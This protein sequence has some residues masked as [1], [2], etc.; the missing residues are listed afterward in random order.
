MKSVVKYAFAG[1]TFL[2]VLPVT[3]APLPKQN[4]TLAA[5]YMLGNTTETILPRMETSGAPFVKRNEISA[6]LFVK[7]NETA[8]ILPHAAI[9]AAPLVKRN[10]TVTILPHPAT[11][12]PLARRNEILSVVRR[13]DTSATTFVKRNETAVPSHVTI[14]CISGQCSEKDLATLAQVLSLIEKDSK[15]TKNWNIS[16]FIQVVDEKATHEKRNITLTRRQDA[17]KSNVTLTDVDFAKIQHCAA[18]EC[19]DEELAAIKQQLEVA[20]IP[21]WLWPIIGGLSRLKFNYGLD[22]GLTP[23]SPSL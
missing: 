20:T 11:F 18:T 17:P 14:E 15:T 19:S 12:E 4:A 7:R 9:S 16:S 23:P 5:R 1:A 8:T 22:Y 3:T 21:K 10:E 6:A 2:Q 13:N